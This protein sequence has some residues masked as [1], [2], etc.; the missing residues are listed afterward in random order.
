MVGSKKALYATLAATLLGGVGIGAAK[1]G[2]VTNYSPVTQQ[3]L[4]HPEAGNW[5]LYRQNYNGQGY[6]PLKQ[7]NAGNVKNTCAG[8]DLF[9]RRE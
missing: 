1:A 5:L 4:E 9:H 2:E 6:S 8:L 3:R 7:I